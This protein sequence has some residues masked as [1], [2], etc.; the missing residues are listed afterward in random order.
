MSARLATRSGWQVVGALLVPA[1]LLTGCGRASMSPKQATQVALE[2]FEAAGLDPERGE[3]TEEV[4]VDRAIDGEFIQVHQVEM[5]ID[6]RSYLAGVNRKLGAVV[7][8]IEPADTKL[9]EEQVDAIAEYRSNPAEDDARRSRTVAG[10]VVTLLAILATVLFFRR[11]RHKAERATLDPLD[12]I[13]L[14]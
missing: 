3:V 12:E 7:R 6:G 8:L 4:T 13:P 1:L 2:A 5:L 9:T 11:E 14:A 10:L